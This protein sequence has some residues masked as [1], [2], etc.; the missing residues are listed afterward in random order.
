[1]INQVENFSGADPDGPD[2]TGVEPKNKHRDV[3]P[4]D[5][6][7]EIARI[8]QVRRIQSQTTAR[9]QAAVDA[10]YR[11]PNMGQRPSQ[12]IWNDGK[13]YTAPSDR[14]KLPLPIKR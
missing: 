2:E 1:M 4:S 12:F 11:P 6:E 3:A 5:R 7:A 13:M 14:N 9:A 10:G 8:D